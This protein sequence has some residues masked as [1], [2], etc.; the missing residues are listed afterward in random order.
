MELR[1]VFAL[2]WK[3]RWLVLLVMVLT[4]GLGTA[5]AIS[6][7]KKYDSTATVAVTPDFTRGNFVPPDTVSALVQT[8]AQTAKSAITKAR[9]NQLAGRKLPGSVKTGTQQ[10]AGI[11]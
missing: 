5:L 2:A 7:P 6:R 4:V 8:Y 9:A 1:D 11:L 3:R 10:D